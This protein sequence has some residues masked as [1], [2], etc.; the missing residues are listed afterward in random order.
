MTSPTSAWARWAD[1]LAAWAWDRLVNRTDAWGGYRP[2][3]EWDREYCKT[4]GTTGKLGKT[5]TRKGT[6]THT[7]LTWHFR[8]RGRADLVGLHSTSP[9]NTSRW[10]AVDIDWH[11]PTSTAPEVNLRAALAWHNWLTASGFNPLLLDSNGKGGFHLWLLLRSPV[12]TPRVYDFLQHLIRDHTQHGMPTAPETFPVQPELQP[13]D[14][15]TAYGNWLRAPGRHHTEP[16]WARIWSGTCWLDGAEAVE[17]LLALQGDHPSLL[18]EVPVAAAPRPVTP[19]P[20]FIGQGNGNNRAARAA[21]YMRRL[22]N[23]GEGQGRHKVAFSFAAFLVR[24]LALADDIALQW[25]RLWDARNNPA[26]GE[27]ELQDV[28]ACACKYAR[29]AVG[30]GLPPAR[31]RRDRH[32]HRILS[33]RVEVW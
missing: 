25:L 16:H 11:G 20:T 31:P 17:F 14:G 6:L 26:L 5:T 33:A 22:P 12:P 8:P 2:P 24:D 32:G 23:L 15:K 30:S 4:D 1:V 19:R 3:E 21:N 7:I 28:L 10:G 27:T 13:Q 29:N 18:P 9:A